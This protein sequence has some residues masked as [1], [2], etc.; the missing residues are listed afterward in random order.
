MQPWAKS[1][2]GVVAT[3]TVAAFVFM[4]L[5]PLVAG[6]VTEASRRIDAATSRPTPPSAPAAEKIVRERPFVVVLPAT[7]PPSRIQAPRRLKELEGGVR[8]NSSELRTVRGMAEGA[9]A[10]ALENRDELGLVRSQTEAT[11]RPAREVVVIREKAPAPPVYKTKETVSEKETVSGTDCGVE[12][13]T[14]DIASGRVGARVRFGTN[15]VTIT[16]DGEF[17]RESNGRDE[18]SRYENGGGFNR[19]SNSR[20]L[21]RW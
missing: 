3:F 4:G 16:R 21:G 2:V 8:D 15:S 12:L 11:S 13:D 20:G 5:L 14:D 7:S 18:P 10:I 6:G 19:R 1:I 9:T 17:R